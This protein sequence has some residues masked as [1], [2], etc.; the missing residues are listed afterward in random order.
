MESDEGKDMKEVSITKVQQ[1]P[2]IIDDAGVLKTETWIVI[3]NDKEEIKNLVAKIVVP[4]REDCVQG[5]GTIKTGVS[6]AIL[7]VPELAQDG[8]VVQFCFYQDTVNEM[9]LVDTIGVAQKQVRHWKIYV[10]HDMHLDI[11][12]TD[13]QEDLRKE[14]FP[15][16]LDEAMEGIRY[17][18]DWEKDDQLKYP[19]E[20]SYL[21]YGSAFTARDADWI[22]EV[23]ENLKNGRM[24][25]PY[26]YLHFA[27][28]GMGVEQVARQNYYSARFL[29]DM[30]GTPPA[31]FAVHTDDAGYSWSQIDALTNVG[32]KYLSWRLQ[33]MNWNYVDR[34]CPKYP[35]LFYLNG[36]LKGSRLLTFDGPVYHFDDFGF[37]ADSTDT[38][39]HLIA[40]SFMDMQTEEYPY[41]SYLIHLTKVR[42]NSGVETN[43]MN[44]I[45]GLNSRRDDQGRRYVYPHFVNSLVEDFFEDVEERYGENI[46]SVQGTLESF[47][48]FGAAQVAYETSLSRENH[49]NVPTAEMFSTFAVTCNPTAKY[50]YEDLLQAYDD[51]MM[52]DEHNWASW[53][54]DVDDEQLKW[55]RSKAMEAGRLAHNVLNKSFNKIESQIPTDGIT[56]TVYNNSLSCRTDIVKLQREQLPK[57][58]EIFDNYTGEKV[59]WQ[60]LSENEI[61]FVG[62]NIPQ[63]GYKTFC[64]KELEDAAESLLE[65]T[66]SKSVDENLIQK[67]QGVTRGEVK[68]LENQFYKVTLDETG[69]ICS[70]IDKLNG[71]QELVDQTAIHKMNQF[72]YYTSKNEL[73][74]N[75]VYSEDQI[76]KAEVALETGSVFSVLVS[77]GTTRGADQIVRKI[78]L[79]HDL[80]YI[81]IVNDVVKADAPPNYTETAEEGFFTFPFHMEKFHITH[82]SPAGE[83]EPYVNSDVTQP[84]HQ[85]YWSNTDFYTV[86][87]WINVNNENYGIMFSTVHAPLVQYGGRRTCHWDKDY[88]IQKPWIYSW[89]FDNFWKTNF[90]YTQPGLVTFRYRLGT[91]DKKNWQTSPVTQFGYDAANPLKANVDYI[92]KDGKLPREQ[93]SFISIGAENVI[94]TTAKMA[95]ANGEGLILRFREIKGVETVVEIDI[96]NLLE[97]GSVWETN[98]VE[99]DMSPLEFQQGKIKLHFMGHEWKTIRLSSLENIPTPK[100]LS[101]MITTRGTHL[102][103]YHEEEGHGLCY[104]IFRDIMEEFVPGEG[105]YVATVEG[106]HY[107]DKQVVQGLTRDY[108][109]KVRCNGIASK[110]KFSNVVKGTEKEVFIHNAPSAPTGLT[111]MSHGNYRVVLSWDASTDELG[112][113]QGYR[114]YRDGIIRKEITAATTGWTDVGLL[115]DTTFEYTVSAFNEAGLESE[116][117]DKIIVKTSGYHN[118]LEITRQGV[119]T[120]SSELGGDYAASNLNTGICGMYNHSNWFPN[121]EDKA[122]WIRIT[123]PTEEWID[124]IYVFGRYGDPFTSKGKL[125]LSDGSTY[126]IKELRVDGSATLIE[127]SLTKAKWIEFRFHEWDENGGISEIQVLTK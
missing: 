4:G 124:K 14:L 40:E 63:Y 113:L 97:D 36:R 104:E 125:I 82:D 84:M 122:P 86:N 25:Y 123:W 110:S 42:D 59:K 12:Y 85:L 109:Y 75:I 83:I 30:L 24:N 15:G 117:S 31:K 93:H 66:A 99:D 60:L 87:Q 112:A 29:K 23:K 57:A 118:P 107:Y 8:D 48:N 78:F 80:P 37:R 53:K 22:Q 34:H 16:F 79:Y 121:K 20:A 38:T 105:N 100:L 18:R 39:F 76:K 35:K 94:L 102:Q 74:E 7:Y 47:W 9:N 95:E 43:V 21:L 64:V 103:W 1:T 28:E 88:Q 70:L 56:I 58:F 33:D 46:P 114:I 106:I 69:S 90:T 50:H 6:K 65:T 111:G 71:D 3:K 13:Y 73:Y 26:N 52:I 81:D 10:A 45:K 2:W 51:M 49:E 27:T 61:V 68:S 98:I 116:Q 91:H 96:S 77:K 108:Y 127:L 89:V 126:D 17:T 101:A 41:D 92:K 119:I 11:G 44:N 62:T 32:Q 120:V 67:E 72:V 54:Y 55:S 115:A 5:L 19:L